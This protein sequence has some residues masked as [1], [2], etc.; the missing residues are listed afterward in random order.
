MCVSVCVSILLMYYRSHSF[1]FFKTLVGLQK[2]QYDSVFRNII[3]G[4]T[5]FPRRDRSVRVSA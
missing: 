3:G 2:F 4:S 1:D 5:L